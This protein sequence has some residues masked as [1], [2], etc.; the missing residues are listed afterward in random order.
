MGRA[1]QVREARARFGA[2]LE[3][4]VKE[5]PQIVTGRGVETAVLLPIGQWRELQKSARPNLKEVLLAP[6]ARTETLTP[7]R[8]RYDH[9]PPPAF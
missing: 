4:S 9:R 1:W 5:G 2:F 6:E 7:P 8:S 3:A